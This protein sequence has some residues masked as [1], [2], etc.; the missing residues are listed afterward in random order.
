MFAMK[1]V[2]NEYNYEYLRNIHPPARR[3]CFQ[4]FLYNYMFLS[5]SSAHASL[6]IHHLKSYIHITVQHPSAKHPSASSLWRLLDP[7]WSPHF[8]VYSLFDNNLFICL[9]H[10]RNSC[11]PWYYSIIWRLPISDNEN[12]RTVE[13]S[14]NIDA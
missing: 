5:I 6:S 11:F 10:P 2:W 8:Q 9:I 3:T 7:L 13:I 4:D 12:N 1:F 14:L